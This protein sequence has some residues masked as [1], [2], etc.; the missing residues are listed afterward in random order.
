MNTEKKEKKKSLKQCPPSA[1]RLLS[2][3]SNRKKWGK[4][5]EH[6]ILASNSARASLTNQLP[7]PSL[8]P[9]PPPFTPIHP[10][11]T[12]HHTRKSASAGSLSMQASKKASKQAPMPF[13]KDLEIFLIGTTQLTSH[14]F[15]D[16]PTYKRREIKYFE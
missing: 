14:L 10:S 12:H 2:P 15:T 8:F 7:L 6:H 16:I 4:H 11:T 1:L 5:K 9:F 13:Q 3:L